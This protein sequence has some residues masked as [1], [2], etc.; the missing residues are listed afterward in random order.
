MSGIL[1]GLIV[2]DGEEGNDDFERR[3][4]IFVVGSPYD[5]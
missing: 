5:L 4:I 1:H 2:R 3:E